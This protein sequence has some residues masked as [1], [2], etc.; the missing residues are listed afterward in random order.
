MSIKKIIHC[1][2]IHLRTYNMHDNFKESVNVFTKQIKKECLGLNKDEVRILIAGDVVHQ[3][4]TISNE[5]LV[6]L[7]KFLKTL[8]KFGKVIIIPGNHDLLENNKERMD[9]ISPVVN[10]IDSED[11][12]YYL[13]SGF[14]EDD[15]VIWCNFS[16]FDN[17]ILD[18]RAYRRDNDTTNK[19]LI[20][21]Y[22]GAINGSVTDIG[23]SFENNNNLSMFFG[24][25]MVMMGD[26]H[27]RQT[28][29]VFE[30]ANYEYLSTK[31]HEEIGFVK[32][33]DGKLIKQFLAAYPGSFF[34]N[35][36]GE[37]VDKHGF[38]VWDVDTCLFTEHDIDTS[39]GFYQ[40]KITSIND[41]TNNEEFL[42]N[43]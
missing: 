25:D 20:S 21:L 29:N 41:F 42:T 2:D 37:S 27:K 7:G 9:S 16:L 40:F 5:Q 12:V 18:I 17:E 8:S 38:L 6:L 19:K 10:F 24:S 34:Q 30:E 32:C 14:Y 33:D 31:Q 43:G 1:A 35:D 36:F 13:K 3:K 4:I 39:Y 15:N 22:H 26:I 11:I 28:F 23:Y